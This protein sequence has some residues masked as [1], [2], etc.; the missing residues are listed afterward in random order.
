LGGDAAGERG[1]KRANDETDMGRR[2]IVS[3]L[4]LWFSTG[5]MERCNRGAQA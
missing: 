4:W 5:F 2:V 3:P 1:E